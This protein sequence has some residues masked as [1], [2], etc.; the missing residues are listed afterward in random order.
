MEDNGKRDA[1][2]SNAG[3][4]G[5]AMTETALLCFFLYVPILMMVIVWGDLTLDKERAQAAA[6][7]MAFAPASIEDQTLREEFFPGATGAPD[8]TLS[9][10]AAGVLTDRISPPPP[11][12]TVGPNALDP[13]MDVQA[14]LFSMAIGE[15]SSSLD[16]VQSPSGGWELTPVVRTWRDET[17]RYLIENEIVA[18]FEL[19]RELYVEP[20]EPAELS[21]GTSAARSPTEYALTVTRAL[22]GRWARFAGGLTPDSS[23]LYLS[24][25]G[26]WTSYRS[27][28]LS[29]L[30]RY[31]YGEE[32]YRFDVPTVGG[33]PG[34]L[35]KFGRYGQ[36]P[37]DS[38][39][40]TGYTY[41]FNPNALRPAEDVRRSLRSLS[42]DLFSF[43]QSDETAWM[44]EMETPVGT[45]GE[46][47]EEQFPTRFLQP[48]DP[49]G[50]ERAGL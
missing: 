36:E 28:Y 22:N 32:S 6:A 5:T 14:A 49:R 12:T 35:M 19:P 4:K 38:T 39:F 27:P 18:G 23:P 7:Y 30:A 2:S 50:D 25:A 24:E 11:Y 47:P 43:E 16:W 13:E 15:I 44:D 29:E 33:Q 41:L 9:R 20:G 17:A 3:R 26:L 8:A 40:K 1:V 37:L 46:M 45:W 21:T 31:S 10:R 48:G 34:V 42:E